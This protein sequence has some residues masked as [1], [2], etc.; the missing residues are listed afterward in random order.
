MPVC[1]LS[2][3]DTKKFTGIKEALDSFT[4]KGYKF[5]S[6]LSFNEINTGA[7]FTTVI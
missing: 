3:T 2:N 4:N 7:S 1:I 5:R 6:S